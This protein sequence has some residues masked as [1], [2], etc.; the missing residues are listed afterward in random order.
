MLL[1]HGGGFFGGGAEDMTPV[2]IWTELAEDGKG[3]KVVGKLADT[4]RGRDVYTLMK[5]TPRPAIDGLSIGYRA[6]EFVQGTKPGEPR[7][8]LKKIDL[9][10]VSIVTFPAN[11]K[12]RVEAV[13]ALEGIQSL[14]DA[15][16]YLRDAC[17]LSRSDAVTLVS[18]IKGI[19]QS[20]SGGLDDVVTLMKRCPL[21]QT[22]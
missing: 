21:L 1:Q 18:R 8:T 19:G 17:G 3:L 20:D 15:E 13:K 14:A 5:M 6:K 9:L 4:P 10:E 2:G 11:P 16:R 22:S 12:A 7:R